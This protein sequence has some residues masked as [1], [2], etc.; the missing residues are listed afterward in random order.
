MVGTNANARAL[1][2]SGTE[3]GINT[4]VVHD[5]AEAT[6][7]VRDIIGSAP[8]GVEQWAHNDV[9][10]VKA[11]NAARLWQVAESLNDPGDTGRS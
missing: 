9:V 5:V 2:E 4:E 1:A 6:Q 11:S 8:A 7:A 3:R 10:L